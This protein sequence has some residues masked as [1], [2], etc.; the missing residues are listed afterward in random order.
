MTSYA[1]LFPESYLPLYFRKNRKMFFGL[2]LFITFVITFLCCIRPKLNAYFLMMLSV[3]VMSLLCTL[4]KQCRNNLV[5]DLARRT[6]IV[7]FLSVVCWI[8]DR[9]FCDFWIRIDMPY[10]H[11]LFHVLVFLSSYCSVVLYA[12]FLAEYKVPHLEPTLTYWPK[13]YS[14]RNR[15]KFLFLPYIAFLPK[16]P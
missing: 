5:I 7:W 8:L 14:N 9:V 12:Y 16:L 3:P 6:F 13:D 11:S 4:T 2:F 1:V 10:M 15:Y